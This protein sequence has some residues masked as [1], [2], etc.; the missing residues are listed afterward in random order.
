MSKRPKNKGFDP[1]QDPDWQK[2]KRTVTPLSDDAKGF[3][4]TPAPSQKADWV[5]QKPPRSFTS[6][7]SVSSP[8]MSRP[9]AALA[10]RPSKPGTPAPAIRHDKKTRRGKIDIDRRID[11][12]DMTHDRALLALRQFIIRSYNQNHS[13]L[14][15]IT[16]KGLRGEGVIRRSFPGWMNDADIR[17]II[18]GYAQAHIRHGGSGA[19]YVFLKSARPDA[20]H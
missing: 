6:R 15:V 2:V 8:P 7:T 18:A 3:N 10:P 4:I 1:D 12:H 16:G 17:P 19:W 11:L 14:L 20:A 13:N 5:V 9:L